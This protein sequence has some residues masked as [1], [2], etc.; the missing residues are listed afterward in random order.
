MHDGF[1]AAGA[2][3]GE[4]LV[5]VA[6]DEP[7]VLERNAK[8]FAQQLRK[9]RRMPLSMIKG[10]G[11]DGHRA[12]LLEADAAHFLARGSGAFEKTANTEPA[13]LAALAAL[14]FPACE[15]LDVGKREGVL[16]NC[17]EVAAVIIA[18]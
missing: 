13:H 8:P 6:L 10:A 15:S 12:V 2:A 5:A 14:A 16:E 7:D 4:E 9:G 17:G 11:N 18:S 3:A 1:G